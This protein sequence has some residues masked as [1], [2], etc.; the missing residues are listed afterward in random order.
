MRVCSTDGRS[1]VERLIALST[2]AVAVCCCSRSCA[3]ELVEQARVLDGDDSLGGEVLDQLDLLVGERTDLLPIDGDRADQH[4]VFK[5]RHTDAGARATER[6]CPADGF[7]G[8]VG[9]VTHL[10]RPHDAFEQAARRWLIS[11]AGL[12]KFGK[13]RRHVVHCPHAHPS[14]FMEV[15][16]AEVGFADAHRVLQHGLEHRLQF[17]GR[18]CNDLQAPPRSPSAAPAPRRASFPG[19]RWMREGGQHQ[20]SPSFRSNEARE[21]VFGSSPPYETRSPRRHSHWSR[22]DRAQPRIEPVNPN[23][24]AR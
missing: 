4:F 17:A 14:I 15:Q 18:A 8:I 3:G 23:R 10:L 11:A 9:R 13:R 16:H 19:R 2:S 1:N 20:C 24:T 21:R 7:S 6:R 12:E 22:C 5:H